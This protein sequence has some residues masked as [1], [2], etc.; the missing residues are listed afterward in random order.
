MN[1][2]LLK[3]PT[4]K[5][6]NNKELIKFLKVYNPSFHGR[7]KQSLKETEGV[8][9]VICSSIFLRRKKTMKSRNMALKRVGSKTCCK[10]C[11]N[12]YNRRIHILSSR[13]F[14]RRNELK[15]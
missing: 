8:V 12:I 7:S 2:N 6:L 3:Y 14:R 15:T 5:I 4:V 13:I 9:C 10:K 11:S 1:N